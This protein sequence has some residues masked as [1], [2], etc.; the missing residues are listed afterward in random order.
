MDLVRETYRLPIPRLAS[1]RSRTEA[2]YDKPVP[3]ELSNFKFAD[4][5]YNYVFYFGYGDMNGSVRT[6]PQISKSFWY[7]ANPG[8]NTGGVMSPALFHIARDVGQNMYLGREVILKHI[9]LFVSFRYNPLTLTS[10][11]TPDPLNSTILTPF[12]ETIY[13]G[14]NIAT[15]PLQGSIT[16][17]IPNQITSNSNSSF[18]AGTNGGLITSTTASFQSTTTI[19]SHQVPISVDFHDDR[20]P[21]EHIM[22]LNVSTAYNLC[23]IRMLLVLDTQSNGATC[24]DRAFDDQAPPFVP[25][26]SDVLENISPDP[27]LGPK[28]TPNSQYKFNGMDRFK[29]LLDFN[30]VLS[31]YDQSQILVRKQ[32]SLPNIPVTILSNNYTANNQLFLIFLSDG[33]KS[34]TLDTRPLACFTSRIYFEDR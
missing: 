23:Q 13:S 17:S 18:L 19:P 3:E 27:T 26:I 8:G 5:I 28:P 32:I 31:A 24:G 4:C 12:V 21:I 25:L 34:P 6:A 30:G 33:F 9:S 7:Q 2:S 16:T 10:N 14:Q 22:T 29:I 15:I 20:D 1:N 11:R